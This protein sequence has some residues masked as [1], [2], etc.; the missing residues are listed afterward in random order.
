[1]PAKQTP[2]TETPPVADMFKELDEADT[3][4]LD[5]NVTPES[6]PESAGQPHL[7]GKTQKPEPAKVVADVAGTQK[8][9]KDL[10]EGTN[11]PSMTQLGEMEFFTITLNVD[12]LRFIPGRKEHRLNVLREW[13][14]DE[15]AGEW[16]PLPNGLT[17]LFRV[18]ED[19]IKFNKA[20]N[21]RK[22]EQEEDLIDG[23]YYE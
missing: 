22:I 11:A 10:S 18:E 15:L 13:C 3:A 19:S 4:A 14:R 2:K 23:A 12:N 6:G 17:W 20:W 8:E 9:I 5:V 7:G 21:S 1:M 16:K